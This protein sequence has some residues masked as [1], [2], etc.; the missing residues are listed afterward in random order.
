[1]QALSAA[2]FTCAWVAGRGRWLRRVAIAMMSGAAGLACGNNASDITHAVEW[3]S[4]P[5]VRIGSIDRIEDAL[6]EPLAIALHDDSLIAIAQW[7]VTSVP[8]FATTTGELRTTI[9]RGGTGPGEFGQPSQLGWLGDT[10]WVLDSSDGV[11]QLYDGDGVFVRAIRFAA[12]HPHTELGLLVPKVLIDGQTILAEPLIDVAAIAK[13]TQERAPIVLVN[14]QGVVIRTIAWHR[15]SDAYAEIQVGDRYRSIAR[16]PFV[17]EEQVVWS[18][19]LGALIAVDAD[20]STGRVTISK[21]G[22][23]ADTIDRHTLVVPPVARSE[24]VV[25]RSLRVF[26]ER[27]RLEERGVGWTQFRRTAESTFSIPDFLPPVWRVVAGADGST[28]LELTRG[29]EPGVTFLVLDD[30]LHPAGRVELAEGGR[31]LAATSQSAWSI[32]HD[33]LAVPYVQEYRVVR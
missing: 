13:G 8:V 20:G 32:V 7:Q 2:P 6:R 28:W 30:Q 5:G 16:N 17:P 19:Q 22:L 23:E 4:V 24:S 31:L 11:L 27:R 18:A 10:L 25:E 14:H 26:Y 3:R 21:I 12:S 9:G 33:S 29:E 1:M 15:L